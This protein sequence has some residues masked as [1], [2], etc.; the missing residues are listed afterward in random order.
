MRVEIRAYRSGATF[1]TTPPVSRVTRSNRDSGEESRSA[2]DAE[3]R[4]PELK[5]HNGQ[6]GKRQQQEKSG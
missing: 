3:V 2:M 4:S 6:Q 1:L 5:R